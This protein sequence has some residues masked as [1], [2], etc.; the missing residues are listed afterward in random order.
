M[1]IW[2][3]KRRTVTF[4]SV[5]RSPSRKRSKTDHLTMIEILKVLPH[6]VI[7]FELDLYQSYASLN[8]LQDKVSW[9]I[10]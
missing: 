6:K 7:Y 9:W 10:N 2:D 4:R 8:V 5:G 1:E 3:T